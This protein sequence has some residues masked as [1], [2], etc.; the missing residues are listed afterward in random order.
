[1]SSVFIAHPFRP[2]AQQIVDRIVRPV[3]KRQGLRAVS[4]SDM[5]FRGGNVGD[6]LRRAIDGCSALIAVVTMPNPNVF[7][8]I[9]V[10][11]ALAKPC[12]LLASTERDA[13]M[14]SDTYPLI[15]VEPPESAMRELAFHLMAWCDKV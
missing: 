14:L 3:L 1:M 12:L 10:A 9:G 5:E 2:E 8:E 6:G 4:G 7:F 15:M 13:C 11:N